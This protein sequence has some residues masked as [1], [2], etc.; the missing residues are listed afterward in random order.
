MLSRFDNSILSGDSG[1][2]DSDISNKYFSTYCESF[3]LKSLRKNPTYFQ[4]HDKP[5]CIGLILTTNHGVSYLLV[6]S[7]L[8]FLISKGLLLQY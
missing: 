1:D 6:Q 4:N 7:T 3:N 2:F 8:D 5:T